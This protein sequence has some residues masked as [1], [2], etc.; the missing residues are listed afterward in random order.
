MLHCNSTT[1]PCCG[2]PANG[3]VL[4]W[5]NR[6][7]PLLHYCSK[8]APD[9][10]SL[11]FPNSPRPLLRDC[12]KRATTCSNLWFPKQRPTVQHCSTQQRP[13]LVVLRSML[14]YDANTARDRSSFIV[15][16]QRPITSAFNSQTAPACCR[17]GVI[18]V[19]SCSSSRFPSNAWPWPHCNLT[20]TPCR[21][22]SRSVLFDVVNSTP[23]H[24]RILVQTQHPVVA[25]FG[26]K[27]VP[28]RG[29]P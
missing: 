11:W 29:R 14:M 28:G 3:V 4:C 2:C 8:T 5:H 15:Q 10:G 7:R 1:T 27:T 16:K 9:R 13:A 20:P 26:S 24:G 25:T 22:A 6:A 17:T 19:P 18:T 21:V 12:C 23:D